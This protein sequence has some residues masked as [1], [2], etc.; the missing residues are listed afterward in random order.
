MFEYTSTDIPYTL[1][2]SV[3][4]GFCLVL[5]FKDAV[6]KVMTFVKGLDLD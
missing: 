2:I 1:I 5:M 4:V 6:I 3:F